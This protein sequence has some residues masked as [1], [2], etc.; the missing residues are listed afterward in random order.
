MM[1]RNSTVLLY[2]SID[3]MLLSIVLVGSEWYGAGGAVDDDNANDVKQE[4][5][6]RDKV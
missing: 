5:G 6:G 1:L 2:W 4:K 3:S